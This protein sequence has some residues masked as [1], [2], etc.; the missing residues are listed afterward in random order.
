MYE[1]TLDTQEAFDQWLVVDVNTDSKTW[2]FDS[3]N[4]A[5]KYGYNTQLAADDWLISP[6]INVSAGC[7][8]LSFEYQGSNY[9]EKMDVFYGTSRDVASMTEPIIDLGEIYVNG[10]FTGAAKMINVAADGDIYLGFHAKSDKDKYKLFVKNVKLVSSEGYDISA[11]SVMSS[12]SGENLAQEPVKLHMTNVGFYPVSNL[13]VSFQVN[14][15]PV[16]TETINETIQVGESYAYTFTQLADLSE[17]GTYTIKAWTSLE[18]DDNFA[19]DTASVVVHHFGPANVPYF[20]GFEDEYSCSS[21]KYFDLN[22][23]PE[24][25]GSGNWSIDAGYFQYSGDNAMV[26]G[27]SSTLPGDD[28]FILEPIRLNAGYYSLKFWY[29]SMG[30]QERFA[31]YYGTEATPEAMTN[32]IVKYDPFL[33][34]EYSESANVIH[35]EEDGV[36]YL[37]FHA[38]SDANMNVICIDDISIEEIEKPKNDLSVVNILSP[39]NGYVSSLQSQDISFSVVNSGVEEITGISVKIA[40]DGSVVKNHTIERIGAQET[41]SVVVENGLASLAPGKHNLTITI[42][43]EADEVPE[44]NEVEIPF[45]KVGDP[46]LFYD[47]ESGTV[48]EDLILASYDGATV[49]SQLIDIFPNNEPWN[50]I[51]IGSHEIYGSWMLV[52]ALYFTEYIPAD[53][54]CIFPQISVN[55]ENA[56]MVWT[57]NSGDGGMAYAETYEVLVSTTNTD[58]S[59]FSVCTTIVDETFA[60]AP[61]TRGIDLGAY[62]GQDIYVA[63]RLITADGFFLT[64]DN[65]G[66]YGDVVKKEF[67]SVESVAADA[68]IWANDGQVVCAAENVQ[69]ISIFDASG[70]LVVD[71]E[72]QSTLDIDNL[73][74][75][76]Y[77]V[78]AMADGEILQTKIVK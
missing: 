52:A 43:C 7:Y 59:S 36:Y 44:N 5:A 42:E 74:N 49:S 18:K 34:D 30:Y 26:Y 73:S 71:C 40:I 38:F 23:D 12:E 76:V 14:Q 27:Y 2:G 17:S 48:P 77:I 68:R 39:V 69:R 64:I 15:Q 9:G 10:Y 24:D 1:S 6:A 21:I 60:N 4:S 54:W 57:A 70:R 66:F 31:V 46:V 20:N 22:Y 11:D 65:I 45:K 29:A 53:R 61:S 56:D 62:N 16:V 3:S 58:P 8:I 35:I 51:E 47:F 63:I 55:S 13:Q 78:R 37:G 41:Q 75:G 50:V 33:S 32:L 28:W 67:S 72:N 25:E 19:N